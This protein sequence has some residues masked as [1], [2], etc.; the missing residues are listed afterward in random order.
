MSSKENILS[1]NAAKKE[2]ASLG[3]YPSPGWEWQKP[4]P[5]TYLEEHDLAKYA[6][7]WILNLVE[8]VHWLPFVPTF[9][10]SF[11]IFQH[12]SELKVLLGSDIQVFLLLVGPLIQTFGGLMG[13][14]MHEYEGWQVVYFE[15]PLDKDV[16]IRDVNNEWLREVAYKLLFFL[17]GAGLLAFSL[18]VFGINK[19]TLVFAIVSGVI[20]FIGPQNPKATFIFN[21]QPVFPL[22]ISMLVVFIVNASVNFVAYFFLLKSALVA[23]HLPTLLAGVVPTLLMFGGVF[24]GLVAESTFNQ[25]WHFTAF[26]FMNL[27][28]F[29]EIYFFG[30]LW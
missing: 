12:S 25:W 21:N 23:A 26:I 14:T 9:I 2:S 29:L 10:L 15:N 16:K 27:G 13:I 11:L 20:A 7:V 17:Q 19:V 22:A 28:V 4:T 3:Y 6:R 30:L 1:N 24:E 8:F 18:G 5:K